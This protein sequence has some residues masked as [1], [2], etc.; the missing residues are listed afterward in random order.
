MAGYTLT[1]LG[2]GVMGQAILSA[3]YNAPKPE[4]KK[5]QNLY[6]SKIIACNG[7]EQAAEQLLVLQAEVPLY[8]IYWAVFTNDECRY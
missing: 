5:I 6:P 3:I 7:D 1:M 4:D 8:N 2:C